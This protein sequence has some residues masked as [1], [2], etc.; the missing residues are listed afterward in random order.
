MGENQCNN[1]SVSKILKIEDLIGEYL[2]SDH[3]PYHL[4]CKSY[5]VE[6][7]DATNL[8]VLATI[9]T[10]VKKKSYLNRS[11]HL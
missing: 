2:G 4:L 10:S 8:K 11:T 6:K 5:T 3:Q 7:L 9:E 1:N